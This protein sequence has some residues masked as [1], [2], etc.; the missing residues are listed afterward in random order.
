MGLEYR[1]MRDHLCA[2]VVSG[3]L[4]PIEFAALVAFNGGVPGLT[5]SDQM[6]QIAFPNTKSSCSPQWSVP[7][8]CSPRHPHPRF[9]QKNFPHP[10][11]PVPPLQ[12]RGPTP[13]RPISEAKGAYHNATPPP[14]RNS[15]PA[16]FTVPQICAPS[17]F[18]Q[19]PLNHIVY[20]PDSSPRGE[21]DTSKQFGRK[22]LQGF[23][24]K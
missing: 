23:L 6:R 11:P 1:H 10:P 15:G 16:F 24:G 19:K 3:T 21:S 18:G 8:G 14:T 9:R 2:V 22:F 4:H 20:W 7:I 12:H 17:D 13:G 5:P